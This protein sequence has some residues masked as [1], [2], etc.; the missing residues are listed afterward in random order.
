MFLITSGCLRSRSGRW[1]GY[2]R[3][4]SVLINPKM[5]AVWES[6]P[7]PGCTGF[8]ASGD[9]TTRVTRVYCSTRCLGTI[10]AQPRTYEECSGRGLVG[11]RRGWGEAWAGN[12]QAARTS[13]EQPC[14]LLEMVFVLR[15]PAVSV[16][17][18]HNIAACVGT[19]TIRVAPHKREKKA[20]I[21]IL[22]PA[23]LP[24]FLFMWPCS[25]FA[26]PDT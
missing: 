12:R 5:W 20:L 22:P 4:T 14:L 10:Q 13:S 24:A 17:I 9:R 23:M 16:V 2:I 1:E 3:Q 8:T 25:P 7:G 21:Y 6:D 11:R 18:F 26:H 19:L 15:H